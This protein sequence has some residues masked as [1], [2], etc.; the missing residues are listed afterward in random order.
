MEHQI[1]GLQDFA[2]VPRSGRARDL[3]RANAFEEAHDLD[4]LL[5]RRQV[6][7]VVDHQRR[8]GGHDAQDRHVR[9][10]L[11]AVA[12]AAQAALR[13]HRQ[14][15]PAGQHDAQALRRER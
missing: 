6:E 12:P 9:G 2:L 8:L 11:A 4:A 13:P 1:R 5:L 3:A 15:R 7:R 14:R 10:E